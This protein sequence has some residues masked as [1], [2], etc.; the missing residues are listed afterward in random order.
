M[1]KISIPSPCHQDWSAMTPNEQGRHCTACA[2]TVVDFAG[3]SDE[4]VQ[5]FFINKKEEKVCGR[6]KNEQLHRIVIELP[7]NI[8]YIPMP[9]WKKFLVASLLVF[10]SALFSCDTVIQGKT[11]IEP[12]PQSAG[13]GG[14]IFNAGQIKQPPDTII[15]TITC[16]STM[17]LTTPTVVGKIEAPP[18]DLILTGD[19]VIQYATTGTPA[20]ISV[21]EKMGEIEMVKPD[22]LKTKNPPKADSGNCNIEIFY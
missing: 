7:Q 16:T 8:F 15:Q 10:S 6:F 12:Q 5:Y 19:T 18:P 3:M 17:G 20:I 9:G 1:L 22:T 4:E 21:T 13:T 2:K 14:T 11:R